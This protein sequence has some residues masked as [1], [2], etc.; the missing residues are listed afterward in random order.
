MG[1]KEWEQREEDRIEMELS[2]K[3]NVI[4]MVRVC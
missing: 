1:E 2:R 3:I 4:V